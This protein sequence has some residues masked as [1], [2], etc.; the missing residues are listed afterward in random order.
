MRTGWFFWKYGRFEMIDRFTIRELVEGDMCVESG[1]FQTLRSLRD[2]GITD[3]ERMREYFRRRHAKGTK[4]FV[5][6][7]DGRIV[8]TMSLVFE[9]KFI[10]NGS[11]IA[12][13]EDVA[14]HEEFQ[15]RGYGGGLLAHCIEYARSQG[16]YKLILDC[17]SE[18][19]RFYAKK[20]MNTVEICMRINLE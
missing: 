6:V 16:C 20:G 7:V 10:H 8:S 9:D 13:G 14:T 11:T 3:F 17:S 1:F 15:E 2:E 18:N 19:V 12:H 4:T 5:G